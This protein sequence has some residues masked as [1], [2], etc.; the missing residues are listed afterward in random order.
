M[1]KIKK[2][3][4]SMIDDYIEILYSI[5]AINEKSPEFLKMISEY[6]DRFGYYEF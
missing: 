1:I 3:P 5:N 2:C 4:K 6:S